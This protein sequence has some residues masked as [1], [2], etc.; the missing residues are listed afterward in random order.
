M[1]NTALAS[2]LSIVAIPA[3]S[4]ESGFFSSLSYSNFDTTIRD[5]SIPTDTLIKNDYLLENA[6]AVPALTFSVDQQDSYQVSLG[7][8]AAAISVGSIRFNYGGDFR[9]SYLGS[10]YV[11]ANF[12]PDL[13]IIRNNI[14]NHMTDEAS[15]A[16]KPYA[17]ILGINDEA[18]RRIFNNVAQQLVHNPQEITPLKESDLLKQLPADMAPDVSQAIIEDIIP[19]M[20]QASQR[21]HDDDIMRRLRKI[22]K[23]EADYSGSSDFVSLGINAFVRAT[24]QGDPLTPYAQVDLGYSVSGFLT[25]NKHG[26][27]WYGPSGSL[28]IGLSDMFNEDDYWN[29][30]IKKPFGFEQTGPKGLVT[31]NPD[32]IAVG[33]TLGNQNFEVQSTFIP[34]TKSTGVIFTYQF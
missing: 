18:S 26:G 6:L 3:A 15:A 13:D 19:L 7:W 32:D 5:L 23:L 14:V 12:N 1:I 10:T 22:D 8:N 20:A 21:V 30:F 2:V 34:K 11:S 9:A 27:G 4:E 17:E 24:F 29:I 16:F 31:H 28:E 25:E 33:L